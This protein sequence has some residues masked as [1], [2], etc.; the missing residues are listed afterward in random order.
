[1]LLR[2]LR[3][4][5]PSLIDYGVHLLEKGSIEPDTYVLDLDAI[6]ENA[7]RLLAAGQK[8]GVTFYCMAKQLGHNPAAARTVLDA[9]FAGMVAVDFRE[10]SILH[11]AGLPVKHVGHLVQVPKNGWERVLDM[12]PDAVT[13][14]SEEKAGEL[15]R[16]A[17]RRGVT[18][19]V[20]L[21]VRDGGDVFYRGQ[22]GGFA[23]AAL[24][25]TAE[26]IGA[27]PGVR[28]A[29]VTSFPCFLY[30]EAAKKALP[31]AN[32]RTVQRGAAL[33]KSAGFPVTQVNMPSCNSLATIP[34]AADLGATHLEPGHSLTGTNQ[35]NIAEPLPLK[36]A[37]AYLTEV[38]HGYDGRSY[39]YGG[40]HYRRSH[41]QYA[42]VK[43]A[44]GYT[45]AAVAEPEAAGIDYHFEVCGA[46]PVGTPVAL[47]FRT[48]IFVTRSHVAAVA[49]LSRGQPRLVGIWDA[50]GGKINH[51][52]YEP[53][54]RRGAK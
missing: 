16:A 30:D 8:R 20:L 21:R 6:G 51:E 40:G 27:L 48:Q 29:G 4:Q 25:E 41:V 10:A 22:E 49:G 50:Q 3:A 15:S 36:P 44:G 39:C 38:S 18:Q 42:A 14:F 53:Y 34:L 43:T 32:A 17:Q 7:E 47:G 28:V 33:L 45:E 2:F 37:L 46:F 12:R 23:L 9:G 11:R 5:N 19:D 52:P 35:D 31:T 1:M 13:L 24:T 54:E 26:R